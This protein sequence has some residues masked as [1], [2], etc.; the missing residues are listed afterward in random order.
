ML[1]G[2]SL[3]NNS[4]MIGNA[5]INTFCIFQVVKK[6]SLYKDGIATYVMRYITFAISYIIHTLTEL[7][8]GKAYTGNRTR[9]CQKNNSISFSIAASLLLKTD[10]DITYYNYPDVSDLMNSDNTLF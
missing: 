10:D 9:Q 2:R 8:F 7:F 5:G 4:V 3:S 1:K 6:F